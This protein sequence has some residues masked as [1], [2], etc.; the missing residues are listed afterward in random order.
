MLVLSR[1]GLSG[2]KPV[3]APASHE[4]VFSRGMWVDKAGPLGEKAYNPDFIDPLEEGLRNKRW[5]HNGG[6]Q[7]FTRYSAFFMDYHGD[8]SKVEFSEDGRVKKL[9][10]SFLFDHLDTMHLK[11]FLMA[12]FYRCSLLKLAND[13]GGLISSIEDDTILKTHERRKL[14]GE[15]KNHVAR[16]V[17]FS[18][19]YWFKELSNQ[20]EGIDIFDLMRK[21][22]RLDQ[23][24]D[25]LKED[26]QR[27]DTLLDS[28]MVQDEMESNA[29]EISFNRRLGCGGIFFGFGALLTGLLGMNVFDVKQA[30]GLMSTSMWFVVISVLMLT[31][32]GIAINQ[33]FKNPNNSKASKEDK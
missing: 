7:G 15:I 14:A 30:T 8:T 23:L 5:S 4:V 3:A 12:T 16:F 29:E 18:N 11:M 27:T 32:F 24:Y 25:G 20:D 1:L 22:F 19:R 9:E 33:A 13:T 26:I 2:I 31:V 17:L 28:L 21:A 10:R 6:E